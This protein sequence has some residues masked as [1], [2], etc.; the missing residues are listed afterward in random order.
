MNLKAIGI[1]LAFAH[2]G[3]CKVSINQHLE[4]QIEA[5][6]LV[7]T[8]GRDKK[9]VRKSSDDLRRA[10]QLHESLQS[11]AIAPASIAF[12][13]VPHGSQSSRASWSLGIA[14]GVLASCPLPVI[15]VSALEVKLASVGKK[16]A[17]KKDMINWAVDNFPSADWIRYRGNLT[18]EN[19]HLA[20][21]I[22]T[23]YA[24]IRTDAFQTLRVALTHSTPTRKKLSV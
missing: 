2:M 9:E 19:E 20:D 1:D 4:I 24:G 11:F 5:L 21:A 22:A 16:T 10:R 3:L 6:H 8:E 23:V 13:E 18:N 15:Q 14:V 17:S 12:A 7:S